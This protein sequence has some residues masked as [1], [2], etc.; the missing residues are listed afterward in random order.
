QNEEEDGRLYRDFAAALKDDYPASARMFVAMAE[1]EAE[2]RRRLFELF[3]TR[4]GDHIPLIRREDV[5]GFIRRQPF[6]MM[7]SFDIEA[8]RHRA[9]TIEAENANFYRR[10]AERTSD[11][12][13]RALLDELADA[14]AGHQTLAHE[15]EA[16]IP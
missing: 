9:E 8:M 5:K 11:L 3:R 1:E 12:E 10:A 4:F 15:L 16:G 6:W 13:L 7:R 14:E 2:H